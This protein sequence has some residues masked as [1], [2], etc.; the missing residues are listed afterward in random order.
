MDLRSDA[1]SFSGIT[2]SS[3]YWRSDISCASS[4]KHH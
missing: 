3:I 4:P 1:Y 2:Y